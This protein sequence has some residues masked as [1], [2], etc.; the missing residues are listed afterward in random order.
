MAADLHKRFINTYDLAENSC[1]ELLL[2]SEKIIECKIRGQSSLQISIEAQ[3]GRKCLTKSD[4]YTGLLELAILDAHLNH[5]EMQM[6]KTLRPLFASGYNDKI[7]YCLHQHQFK[8]T[9]F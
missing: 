9:D 5:K 7:R 4:L 6:S 3:R 2:N 1:K 8:R